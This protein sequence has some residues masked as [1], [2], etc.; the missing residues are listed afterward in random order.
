[1]DER[2]LGT[3]HPSWLPCAGSSLRSHQKDRLNPTPG[4]GAWGTKTAPPARPLASGRR[5]SRGLLVAPPTL[6]PGAAV[7]RR[8][9]GQDRR[10]GDGSVSERE[11][12]MVAV[13]ATRSADVQPPS[14]GWTDSGIVAVETDGTPARRPCHTYARER[15]TPTCR[16][17]FS[18]PPRSRTG[19]E[20]R[21]R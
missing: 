8:P 13:P 1:V 6:P 17:R 9:T 10:S 20:P 11:R 15:E 3:P 12:W 5:R 18:G 7:V 21:V 2:V 16:A 19:G 4:T 14:R